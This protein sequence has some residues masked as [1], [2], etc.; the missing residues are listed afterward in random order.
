MQVLITGGA[1]F[2]GAKLARAL[3]EKGTL[4]DGRGEQQAITRITLLDRSAATGFDDARIASAEGDVSDPAVIAAHL[5]PATGSV[6]H[7]AAVVSGEAEADFDLGMRINL[8]ATRLLLEQARKNG[9]VP[10]FV[11]TSSVA[12][13]GG[14]LPDPVLDSTAPTPQGS[15][16]AQKVMGELLVADY[17]RKGYID[18]RA[19]RL[20][21]ITV[22][23]GKAN[24]AASSFAS[25]IIR[26]PLNGVISVCPVPPETRVWAMS[27]RSA[28]KNLV[29]AHEVT[30]EALGT[31]GAIN[32]PGLAT[33]AGEMVAALARVAGPEV[34]QRVQWQKDEAITRLVGSWP[35]RFLT[36]RADRLGFV[37]D[38]DFDSVVRAYV[39]EE[40][41]G[42]SAP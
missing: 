27:P 31:G 36:P 38:A 8:D 13:F 6:F 40:L 42:G 26:E 9:N 25:G 39:E 23:P 18:G 15:Y 41:G 22:R 16:G 14:E 29:Q 19:I 4:A 5:T 20:P 12:A 3:L 21:T 7:L 33:T 30:R 11:F 1:G 2:L 35:G 17:S 32:L 28:V 24:K 37:G 34:A 10:R